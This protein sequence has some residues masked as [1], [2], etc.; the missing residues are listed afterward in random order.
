VPE[1]ARIPGRNDPCHCGSGKKYKNCCLDKDEAKA[2]KARV[3][4]QSAEKEAAAAAEAPKVPAAPPKHSTRQPWKG[5]PQT[6]RGFQRTNIP[7]R[8]GGS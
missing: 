5:G 7:R 4:A 3:Q 2:R 6:P 1:P 8:S